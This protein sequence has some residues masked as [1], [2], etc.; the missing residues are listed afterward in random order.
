[1]GV[2]RNKIT[3]RREILNTLYTKVLLYTYPNIE[4]LI[5]QVDELVNKK[6]LTSIDSNIPCIDICNSVINLI[7]EK[8]IY[9]DIM[10]VFDEIFKSL[11]QEEMMCIEYKYF[12]DKERFKSIDFDYTSKQYFRRQNYIVE[13]VRK[14][15][16]K[17]GIDDNFFREKCL[18][19][20][21]FSNMLRGVKER[22][23][24]MNKNKKKQERIIQDK[25]AF[26]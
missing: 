3:F 25:K 16:D 10:V 17:H 13:K 19:I 14:R 4:S 22:E 7:R 5:E 15:L 11:T 9:L 2:S 8:D 18:P 26:A 24:F 12:M 20:K 1:M 21:F 6:A 23:K